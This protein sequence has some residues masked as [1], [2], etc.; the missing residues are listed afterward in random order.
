MNALP[1]QRAGLTHLDGVAAAAGRH[2]LHG[3]H[4]R[5]LRGGGARRGAGLRSAHWLR[6][7]AIPGPHLLHHLLQL[8]H[9]LLH[10]LHVLLHL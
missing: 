2:R 6:P 4:V 5:H 10:R 3:V 7:L 1:A 8:A 9:I